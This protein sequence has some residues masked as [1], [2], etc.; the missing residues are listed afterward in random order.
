MAKLLADHGCFEI[1]FGFESGSQKILD[2]IKKRTTV[3]MNY[4]AVEWAKKHG[5]YVKGF[6]MLGLPGENL[7]TVRE[8]ERFIS[9]SGMDDFQLALYYP[10]RGTQIRDNLE[11][12]LDD[13][14]F[15]GEGLG[16]YGQKGGSTESVVRTSALSSQQ[17]LQIRD[18]LV[19]K[20][21]PQSH[22]NKW[23]DEDKM[24]D[25]HLA[26]GGN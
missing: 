26:R 15:E 12:G 19:R 6:V 16:A 25:T 8:T 17:L 18:D 1:A 10:Y 2:N 22:I 13:L 23:K 11:K 14:K 7:D 9:T 24:F 3:E 4:K 20:Y 5:I 21:K